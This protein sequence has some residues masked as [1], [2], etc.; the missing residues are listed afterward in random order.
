MNRTQT[1][2]AEAPKANKAALGFIFAVV[3]LDLIG[4]TILIPVQVYIVRQYSDDA[5][6]VT[7]MMVIY[8]AAQFFA[9]PLLGALSDRY[10]RRPVLLLSVLGSAFGYYLFGVGGALWVLLLSRLIDGITGGN[11]ATA[12]AYIADIT[13][14]HER[15][16]SFALLGA[17]F[18]LGFILGPAL[19]GLLSQISLA[20]PAY[21]AGTLSLLSAIVGFFV[22]P[23]SLPREQRTSGPLRLA[24][25]NPF[26][27]IGELLRRPVLNALLLI[28]CLFTFVIMGYNSITGV[29]L[30]DRFGVQPLNIAGLLVVVGVAN[31]VVQAGLV[32]RLAARF[33]EQRLAIVSLLFQ[34]L[35]MLSVV[36]VPFFWML[37]PIS[38]LTSG[39][40][41]PFRPSMSALLANRLEAEE[42]GKL[43][44][45][46]TALSSLMTVFGPLWAG[47]TYDYV[48]PS[49]PFWSGAALLV[50][51]SLALM[52]VKAAAQ[53]TVE[54]AAE[55]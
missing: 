54:S 33:G 48:A 51:A 16:K 5:L 1:I 17:A 25:V 20:A 53:A 29:Y 2:P 43:N 6:M 11:L 13:P 4:M 24:E 39:G 37:Y 32:G 44:G 50:L 15:A 31:V 36:V 34:A 55:I 8:A 35:G 30:L 38:A 21:A 47:A 28:Q 22:L 14:R 23:E 52:R 3:L 27:L 42:Q 19:G 40:A 12:S 7:L 26:A 10:G 45:V 41:G 18:G 49:A 9:A 46:S